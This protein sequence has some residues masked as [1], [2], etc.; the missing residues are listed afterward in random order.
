VQHAT[1]HV[2]T[3]MPLISAVVGPPSRSMNLLSI[4][5]EPLADLL[6]FPL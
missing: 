3:L 1:P 5:S 2:L 4:I 6:D